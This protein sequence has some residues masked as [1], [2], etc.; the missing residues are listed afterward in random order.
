MVSPDGSG[1]TQLRS[2]G[3]DAR[4]SLDGKQIAFCCAGRETYSG[5]IFVMGADG[6]LMA[7]AHHG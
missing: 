7:F 5:G 4:W 6:S 1:V 2:S 3:A